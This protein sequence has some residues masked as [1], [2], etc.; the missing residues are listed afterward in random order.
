MAPWKWCLTRVGFQ[1]EGAGGVLVPFLSL[2]P[3]GRLS[4]GLPIGCFASSHTCPAW[5]GISGPILVRPTL[6]Y[7]SYM[8]RCHT[9]PGPLWATSALL[10]IHEGITNLAPSVPETKRPAAP[11]PWPGLG[12][13]S[14]RLLVPGGFRRAEVAA[15][16]G[17][18]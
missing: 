4:I 2:A 13:A 15:K 14:G 5:L 9:E 16:I 1:A 11:H 6:R 3:R 12:P 10:C 18:R 8:G 17:R 7:V